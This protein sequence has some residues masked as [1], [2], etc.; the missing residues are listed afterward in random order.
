MPPQSAT[1]GEEIEA[2]EQEEEPAGVDEI[3]TDDTGTID[4]GE[5]PTPL[6]PQVRRSSRV[7]Q[8]STRY[9]T[10]NYVLIIDEGEPQSFQ[11]V[12]THKNKYE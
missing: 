7:H 10:S 8:P 2:E 12:K 6:E 1:N 3:Y 9:H 11:E 5:L 4:E